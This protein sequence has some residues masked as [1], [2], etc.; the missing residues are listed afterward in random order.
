MGI[1]EAVKTVAITLKGLKPGMKPELFKETLL[2]PA[3]VASVEELG[4]H[5][6]N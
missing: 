1:Q 6:F 3:F 2:E 5:I 4:V